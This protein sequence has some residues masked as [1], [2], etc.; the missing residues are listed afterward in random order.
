MLAYSSIA[1]AGYALVG[2]I[3]GDWKPVAFYMLSYSILTVGSFAIITLVARKGD[4]LVTLDD[5]AGIG[6]KSPGLSLTLSL[7]LASLAGF[8]LTAGFMGKFLVF[9]SAWNKNLYALVIV[10]VLNS[11]ASVYYYLRPIVKMFF[12]DSEQSYEPERIPPTVVAALVIAVAGTIYLGIF[13]GTVL[14]LLQHANR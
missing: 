1:H 9:N 7:F 3:A 12:T 11:A 10:G 5:Y 13:P 8:P 2:F 14:N 6:F 4:K